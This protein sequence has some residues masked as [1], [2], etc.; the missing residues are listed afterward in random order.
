[1]TRK[2]I[3]AWTALAIVIILWWIYAPQLLN[4]SN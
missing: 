4:G 2:E 3:I 1:M